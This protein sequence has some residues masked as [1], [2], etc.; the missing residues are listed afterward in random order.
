MATTRE[1][2][3]VDEKGKK[4]GVVLSLRR[5]QRLMEDLHD[6]A[7]VAERRTEKPVLAEEVRRRL[8]EDGLL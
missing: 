4:T 5:Y 8:K 1:Q 7:V 3:I 6:L 2:F